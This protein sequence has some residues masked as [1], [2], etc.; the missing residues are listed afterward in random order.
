MK[1]GEY[2]HQF[3]AIDEAQKTFAVRGMM[4]KDIKREFLTAPIDEIMEKLE[5]IFNETMADHGP[6]PS[7]LGN[8][9]THDVKVTQ[10][11]SDTSN[12]MSY[13]DVCAIACKGTGK[14]GPNGPGVWHR[15][16]GADEL[17]S[18]R[19][20]DGGKKGSKKGTKEALET[21]ADAK[22]RARVKSDAAAE[23]KGMSE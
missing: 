18:A 7:D 21:K 5:I 22:A 17:T 6:V 3:K 8:V 15:G 12:D 20:Y 10:S 9:G 16:K 23:S 4:P 13:D 19:R 14:K 11:D 2:E 1:V